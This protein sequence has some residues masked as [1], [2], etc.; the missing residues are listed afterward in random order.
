MLLISGIVSV[1]AFNGV[2][3]RTMFATQEKKRRSLTTS[4]DFWYRIVEAPYVVIGPIRPM[5]FTQAQR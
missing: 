4:L 1:N 3:K 5:R 2:G